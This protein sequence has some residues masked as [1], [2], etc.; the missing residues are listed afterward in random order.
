TRAS[1]RSTARLAPAH[2]LARCARSARGED[3]SVERERRSGERSGG[4][5]A[6]GP[7]ALRIRSLE[8]PGRALPA[9]LA[10]RR[11]AV[12]P[13]LGPARTPDLRTGL[14]APGPRRSRAFRSSDQHRTRR[15]R[16]VALVPGQVSG[17]TR[18]DRGDGGWIVMKQEHSRVVWGLASIGVLLS[19]ACT[20]HAGM[21]ANNG[22]SV[23]S[24]A[25]GSWVVTGRFAAVK[26]FGEGVNSGEGG[27]DGEDEAVLRSQ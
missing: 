19:Q 4:D 21:G 8:V 25:D 27:E 6:G 22:R 14:R 18:S 13:G 7:P 26:V 11:S 3:D 15:G 23:A 24:Y 17:A 10:A 12:D 9:H 16:P 5:H 20:R 2:D 1:R